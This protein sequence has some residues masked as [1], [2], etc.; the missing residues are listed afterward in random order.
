LD[1]TLWVMH[2]RKRT[3]ALLLLL[4][5]LLFFGTLGVAA[6]MFPH[7]YD[8]RYRVISN[9][10]SPRDNPRHYWLPAC[11]IILA[12]L[13]VLPFV[14][15]VYQNLKIVSPRASQCRCFQS[16]D[17]RTDLRLPCCAATRS[18]GFGNPALA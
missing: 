6:W 8:W 10:L 16:R 11:G 4:I 5:A 12:A 1:A 18:R 9:L 7:N 14:A 13:L 3:L 17:Y 2:Y 15:Y